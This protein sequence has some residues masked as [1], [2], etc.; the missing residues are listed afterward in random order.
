MSN[1]EIKRQ[2]Q[3][4]QL[5]I[6]K[7]VG[8]A[9]DI[10]DGLYE[11]AAE[12]GRL[13]NLIDKIKP[14]AQVLWRPQLGPS[15]GRQL[16]QYDWRRMLGMRWKY[17]TGDPS[18]TQIVDGRLVVSHPKERVRDLN[19]GVDLTPSNLKTY[20]ISHKMRLASNFSV[21][22]GSFGGVKIGGGLSGGTYLR[23]GVA[24]PVS[25]GSVSRD[26]WSFKLGILG[27]YLM[28]Y[29]YYSNRPGMENNPDVLYGHAFRSALK[30]EAAR[31]YDIELRVDLNDQDVPNGKVNLLVDDVSVAL[32]E[33]ILFNDGPVFCDNASIQSNHGGSDERW[34]PYETTH[35]EYDDFLVTGI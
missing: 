19:T 29:G 21:A 5:D 35:I 24:Q 18:L 30:W 15:E 7:R 4:V 25:G 12:V 9:K 14:A 17:F 13:Q 28:L 34:A 26:G 32:L 10:L 11:S 20:S 27:E 33:N 8:A 23:N 31:D 22:D 16:S 1:L 6:Q 2:L 3:Q